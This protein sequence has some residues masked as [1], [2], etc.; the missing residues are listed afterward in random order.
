MH[1]SFVRTLLLVALCLL[2]VGGCAGDNAEQTY[3]TSDVVRAFQSVGIELRHERLFLD[4]C[5]DFPPGVTEMNSGCASVSIR[6]DGKPL[7]EKERSESPQVALY[8]R[9]P[10]AQHGYVIWIYRNPTI[11][12]RV[13]SAWDGRTILGRHAEWARNGNVLVLFSRPA[14]R[15]QL[16]DALAK[17]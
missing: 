14:D 1:T 16:E 2:V 17:L 13:L 4:G 11:A 6:P 10:L 9:E 15:E 5:K 12:E 8:P 3:D 7:T